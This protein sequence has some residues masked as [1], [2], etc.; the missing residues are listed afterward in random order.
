DGDDGSDV[1][2]II[3][4][5]DTQLDLPCI[6]AGLT[7]VDLNTSQVA[8]ENCVLDDNA[9]PYRYVATGEFDQND[10]DADIG[11]FLLA[12]EIPAG[13]TGA[14]ARFYL[15]ATALARRPN[16]ENQWYV[17]Q[18][19]HELWSAQPIPDPLIQQQAL[20]AYRSLLTYFYDEALT[21]FGPFP[22]PI[23]PAEDVFIPV[24]L[25]K[26]TGT[27]LIQPL[28]GAQP[29]PGYDF[30]FPGDTPDRLSARFT[31]SEWG[32]FYTPPNADDDPLTL[33]DNEIEGTIIPLSQ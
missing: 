20:N 10:P 28:N 11:K 21:Y 23:D 16:G 17:A 3:L 24:D 7:T 15:W 32:F 31:L 12:A 14:K 30:L 29:D 27:Y 19:L 4:P 26:R 5:T 9:N 1:T 6:N 2:D 33:D 25:V 8:A 22:D 18:A 13:P